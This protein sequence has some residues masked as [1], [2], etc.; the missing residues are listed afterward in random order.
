[1]MRCGKA[2]SFGGWRGFLALVLLGIIA[3]SGCTRR[4]FR[5]RADKEVDA[6]LAEKDVV[7]LWK[8]EQYGVYPD[9]RAR[10][11]DPTNPD[12]PPMPPDDPAARDLSPNPQKPPH[13]AG[14]QRVEGTGYLELLAL[15]DAHNRAN[16]PPDDKA[17]DDKTPGGQAEEQDARPPLGRLPDVP[18]PNKLPPEKVLLVDPSPS[19]PAGSPSTKQAKAPPENVLLTG[20]NPE[21]SAQEKSATEKFPPESAPLT[22]APEGPAP[23]EVGPTPRAVEPKKPFLITQEQA[24]ELGLVNSR[25]YQTRREDLYLTALPV[26]LERFGFAYQFFATSEAIREWTGEGIPPGKGDRWRVNSTAGFSKLFSTG[27]LLLLDFANQT[28]IELSDRRRSTSVS[29]INLDLIQP[30]LRGGGKAVTLE[31]LTQAER[32]LL[33]DIRDFA[34]FRKE[35]FQY[36]SGGGNLTGIPG[37]AVSQGYLPTLQALSQI[38][39]AADNVER[40]ENALKLF[41][42]YEEGGEVSQLNVGNVQSDLLTAQSALLAARRD[43]GDALDR[44]KQQLGVPP[45]VPLELDQSLVKPLLDQYDRYQT[46]L[47]QFDLLVKELERYDDAGEEPLKMRPR[48]RK[49]LTES[50]VTRDTKVFKSTIE[51]RWK[52]WQAPVTDDAVLERL[53]EL[54]KRRTKLLDLKADREQVGQSLTREERKLLDQTITEMALGDMEAMLRIYERQPWKKLAKQI[55]QLDARA[56]IFRTLRNALIEVLGEALNERLELLQPQWPLLAGVPIA[57]VDLAKDDLEKALDVAVETAVNNRLDLMNAR[58]QVVD[59]WRQVAVTANSLL[60]VFNIAYH[61]DSSTPPGESRPFAFQASQTRHQLILNAELPLVRLPERNVYRAAL[62]EYQR[63]RRALQQVED[64]VAAQ[65]RSEVR[66]LQVLALNYEIRKQSVVLQ[67][68]I[69]ENSLEEFRAPQ[70]VSGGGA[71]GGGAGGGGGGAARPSSGNVIA[72]TNQLLQAY[73]RLAGAQNQLLQTLIDYQIARQQLYLDLELMP[74][75]FRGVW[76]DE[77]AHRTDVGP[78]QPHPV[79][80]DPVGVVPP[81]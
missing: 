43:Y 16:R 39:I 33:Y 23:A 2:A 73:S 68:K 66:Q 48:I 74:L 28:V 67:F 18:P 52:A 58:A 69:L 36:I 44:L 49:V 65:V 12:R 17:P 21:R 31:P 57:G 9:P 51:A 46:T 15:W 78:P 62:I 11:A 80:I 77:H 47:Q 56:Q 37:A 4:F 3:S 8:I 76:I 38:K 61:M 13:K 41:E 72:L 75:D 19:G 14:I 40:L 22:P 7:P 30:L 42:A 54:K 26:T 20:Q 64:A 34:R 71:G 35:Y 53:G 6:V 70:P 10:F 50:A 63:A 24:V 79:R 27:A 32:N 81:G 1:M 29:T 55:D 5:N 45:P 59:A 25:E 60:G